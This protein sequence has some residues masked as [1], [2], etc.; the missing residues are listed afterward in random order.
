MKTERKFTHLHVHTQ[1]SILDGVGKSDHWVDRAKEIG[2]DALGISDHGN[3]CGA[4]DF[5]KECKKKNIKPVI[6]QE[7]YL[8]KNR[9]EKEKGVKNNHLLLMARNM[10]GYE[11]LLRLSSDAWLNGM[12]YRPRTDFEIIQKHNKG[13]IA[14]SAC[15]MSDIAQLVL[16]NKY[17][18]ALRLCEQYKKMFKYFFLEIQPHDI[19]EFRIV[20][21]A[22]ASMSETLDI[23]LVATNDC[24]YVTAKDSFVQDVLLLIQTKKTFKDKDKWQ[25]K[26]KEFYLKS[27]DEMVDS[28]K[29]Y[30]KDLWSDCESKILT[31][32]SN[33]HLISDMCNV[34]IPLGIPM[35]PKFGV[36][37]PDRE[38][39][40]LC[41]IGWKNKVSPMLEK[42]DRDGYWPK[43][44]D[45]VTQIDKELKV[46]IDMKL[47]DYFLIIRD[48]VHW[49]RNNG[50]TVGSARGSVAGSLVAYALD[51]TDIDPVKFG[52]L[53]ERFLTY[54]R[55]GVGNIPD[56]DLDFQ[57]DRRNEI[58]KYLENKWGNDH[59]ASIIT[60]GTMGARAVLKDVCRVF[61][62]DY[63]EV[64]FVNKFISGK[65]TLR[66]A[67]KDLNVKKFRKKYKKAYKVAMRL[68]GQVRHY[69]T[70]AAGILITDKPIVEVCPVQIKG[71]KER[72]VLSQWGMEDTTARGM[73]KID[74]LGL[75]TLTVIKEAL[76]LIYK[77]HHKKINLRNIS[78]VDKKVYKE[79]CAGNTAGVFQLENTDFQNLLRNVK[80]SCI[81]D[82]AVV[83]ALGRPGAK[84][85]EQDVIYLR[86][87]RKGL[88][89]IKYVHPILKPIL[90]R[91]FGAICFQEQ[92]MEICNKVGGIPIGETNDIREAIKHFKH[93]VM[94]SFKKKFIKGS[95]K[96][97]LTVPQ[98]ELLWESILTHSSYS[99]NRNHATSYSLLSY[100]TMYLKTH[101]PKEYMCS[102]MRND[103]G[104]EEMMRR[105]I[106]ELK[107]LVIPFWTP[108]AMASGINFRIAKKSGNEGILSGFLTVKG[109]GFKTALKLIDL[110]SKFGDKYLDKV[111]DG[112]LKKLYEKKLKLG[113][114]QWN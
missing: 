14:T 9:L 73:L 40:K 85:A 96:N 55:K 22:Y 97:G 49:A 19:D 80:P 75:K 81:E 109:I 39:K 15:F 42:R 70:H 5:Y 32:M 113:S 107:R 27:Y 20:N 57:H 87:K 69:S 94:A 46:I 90:D 13:L 29:K 28:F 26:T 72:L 114:R 66:T 12:Y 105:Y 17:K 95:K 54:D 11:N 91:T 88:A 43:T 100:Y 50:I 8:V 102:I 108:D 64:N 62:I 78:L 35:I 61:S 89:N 93:D 1:Y 106:L 92:V 51:I 111:P 60:F 84:L 59:V 74:L 41:K 86:N 23:P 101:Y 63:N 2:C 99:F 98:A 33:S 34:E 24:H 16:K 53:F 21:L 47:S 7:F 45:Y 6:G 103:V 25:F 76:K 65:D 112:A 3:M 71:G 48:M 52:L 44:A 67:L 83:N 4:I 77:R 82:I 38:L 110:R 18:K 104:N 79:F 56:I 68:E 36:D 37:D 58:K 31:A 10:K 30:H